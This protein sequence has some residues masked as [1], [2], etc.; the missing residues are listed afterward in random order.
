MYAQRLK[1]FRS[2]GLIAQPLAYRC[3]V[4]FVDEDG[5]AYCR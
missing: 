4:L 5:Y 2:S 1:A 3:S